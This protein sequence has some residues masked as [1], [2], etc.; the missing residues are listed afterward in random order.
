[1]YPGG[2]GQENVEPP[3]ARRKKTAARTCA[4][5]LRRWVPRRQHG[6]PGPPR[7]LDVDLLPFLLLLLLLLFIIVIII[8]IIILIIITIMNI[9]IIIII[10]TFDIIIIIIIIHRGL[11][12]GVSDLFVYSDSES[13]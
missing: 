4:P 7:G 8:I 2:E 3:D 11:D 9:I 10:T 6:S 12:I 5:G 13:T 1:M